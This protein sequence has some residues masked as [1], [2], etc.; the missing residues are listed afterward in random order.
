MIDYWKRKVDLGTGNIELDVEN[1]VNGNISITVPS[2]S[3]LSLRYFIYLEM[4]H[5][6]IQYLQL[7]K[8]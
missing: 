2:A 4:V 1:N 3:S 7:G 5:S 8:N 6:I